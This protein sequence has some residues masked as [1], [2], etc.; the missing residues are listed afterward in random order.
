MNRNKL[1]PRITNWVVKN[2]PKAEM[3]LLIILS[4]GFILKFFLIPAGNPV[5]TLTLS[6]LATFYFILAYHDLE[7]YSRIESFINKLLSF[8]W[9]ISVL[10]ILFIVQGWNG[11]N[12]MLVVGPFPLA[13]LFLI[14]I[15]LKSKNAENYTTLNSKVLL[16]TFIIAT[17]S[18]LFLFIPK[19]Q[20]ISKHIISEPLKVYGSEGDPE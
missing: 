18:L 19:E 12:S 20:L 10:G 3:I 17:L 6:T 14:T 13:I 9:S 11:Y 5:I 1:D 8:G 16:R 15:Y 7:T 4:A 2:L